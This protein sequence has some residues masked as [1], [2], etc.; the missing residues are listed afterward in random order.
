MVK[1]AVELESGVKDVRNEGVGVSEGEVELGGGVFEVCVAAEKGSID[2][3][4][5]G[6]GVEEL[7]TVPDIELGA[8]AGIGLG[9]ALGT[10][11]PLSP[12][13][14]GGKRGKA[15]KENLLVP[16]SQHAVPP[17]SSGRLESQQ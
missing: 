4:V 3:G 7:S 8:A 13:L 15:A 14:Y 10:L 9:T 17:D 11:S 16:A 12:S 1:C 6:G 5:A 2:G